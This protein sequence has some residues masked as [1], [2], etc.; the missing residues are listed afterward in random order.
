VAVSHF[1]VGEDARVEW[2][3]VSRNA[4]PDPTGWQVADGLASWAFTF[5][6]AAYGAGQQTIVTRLVAD[7]L[8]VA[9]TAVRARFR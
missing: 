7:D 1:T 2:Q 4:A 8:E 5:S 3:V 6:T 9:R